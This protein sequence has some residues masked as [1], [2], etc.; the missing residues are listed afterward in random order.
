MKE[1]AK[2]L[3][4]QASGK[5]QEAKEQLISGSQEEFHPT[6]KNREIAHNYLY[7]A[8]PEEMN[9]QAGGETSQSSQQLGGK[10]IESA[11]TFQATPEMREIAH[12]YLYTASAEEMN[13]QAGGISGQMPSTTQMKD[14]ARDKLDQYKEKFS[15]KV[16]DFQA[17]KSRPEARQISGRISEAKDKIKGQ[18]QEAKQS[19]PDMSSQSQEQQGSAR[20]QQF[21]QREFSGSESQP[22]G[23]QISDKLG[24]LKDKAV[25]QFQE[26]KQSVQ[27]MSSQGSQQSGSQQGSEQVYKIEHKEQSAISS[28]D[29]IQ[30]I[31]NLSQQLNEKVEELKKSA[32]LPSANAGDTIII[33]QQGG[34]QGIPQPSESGQGISEKI[35][36]KAQD[37]KESI[38]QTIQPQESQG[39]QERPKLGHRDEQQWRLQQGEGQ[40]QESQGQQERPKLG[41]RDEQQWRHR[42][43]SGPS[44]SEKIS[45]KGQEL[46]QGFKQGFEKGH[47][48]ASSHLQGSEGQ[49]G[50][51]DKISNLIY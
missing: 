50:L 42:Q 22:Q 10:S 23:S 18:I 6:E 36:E 45:E 28:T 44:M 5:A 20:P 48:Q 43:E 32:Q 51:T 40:S 39:Q 15:Q 25:G 46:K 31:E 21:E 41:K 3:S 14:T 11:Q 16:R 47:E 37:V 17:S 27:N 26:A 24:E 7:T 12:N 19:L 30:E 49:S 35:S 2:D 8:P 13:Q 4:N 38:K 33:I 34:S 9:Q 29:K 1:G